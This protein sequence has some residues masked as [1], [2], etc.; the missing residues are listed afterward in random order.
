MDILTSPNAKLARQM[1]ELDRLSRAGTPVRS[2][3]VGVLTPGDK[4]WVSNGMRY[5]LP[6]V[7]E[8]AADSL[9]ARWTAV[10]ATIVLPTGDAPNTDDAGRYVPD[11]AR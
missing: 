8:A 5:R 6:N 2:F 10:R 9:A 4:D 7:A 1:D 3:K 11:A